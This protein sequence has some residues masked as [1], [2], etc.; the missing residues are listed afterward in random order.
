MIFLM[1]LVLLTT[2][3]FIYKNYNYFLTESDFISF[4]HWFFTNFF[5]LLQVVRLLSKKS[6]LPSYYLSSE[7]K[8][9]NA[10]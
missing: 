7:F 1:K 4:F 9:N 2:I 3:N 10:F 6:R 8:E 5:K